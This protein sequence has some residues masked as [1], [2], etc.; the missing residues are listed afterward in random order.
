VVAVGVIN[1][2]VDPLAEGENLRLDFGGSSCRESESRRQ[3]QGGQKE[4][5]EDHV[6]GLSAVLCGVEI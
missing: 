3:G 6:G 5:G 2:V 1:D 4:F